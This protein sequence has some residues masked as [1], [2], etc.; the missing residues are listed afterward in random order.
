MQTPSVTVQ[1]SRDHV[2]NITTSSLSL[3]LPS[4]TS[5]PADPHSHVL[6]A[7]RPGWDQPAPSRSQSD[8]RQNM[9]TPAGCR[10]DSVGMPV[11]GG[12]TSNPGNWWLDE[13]E[14]ITNEEFE[15]RMSYQNPR[16]DQRYTAN[17]NNWTGESDRTFATTPTVT[18]GIV[19]G[20]LLEV[21]DLRD[22]MYVSS[23]IRPNTPIPITNFDVSPTTPMSTSSTSETTVPTREIRFDGN[24]H[25][26]G[27]ITV[28]SRDSRV[29]E[30]DLR[31]PVK[32]TST[33][34]SSDSPLQSSGISEVQDMVKTWMGHA[35]RLEEELDMKNRLLELEREQ[36][37]AR[38]AKQEQQHQQVMSEMNR[39]RESMTEF[40]NEWQNTQTNVGIREPTPQSMGPNFGLEGI[41]TQTNRLNMQEIKD[42]SI[43]IPE[44]NVKDVVHWVR[45]I[46]QKIETHRMDD[47]AAKTLIALKGLT[48]HESA[49]MYSIGWQH[50]P[51]QE[52]LKGLLVRY[53]GGDQ[54]TRKRHE[55]QQMKREH[56]QSL[57]SWADQVKLVMA[58][59]SPHADPQDLVAKF[60]DGLQGELHHA[61]LGLE[62]PPA[63][64]EDA[65][66]KA[67]SKEYAL[68]QSRPQN[69]PNTM[70]VNVVTPSGPAVTPQ[71]VEDTRTRELKTQ[72]AELQTLV[73][74]LRTNSRTV[75]CYR[76]GKLGHVRKDCQEVGRPDGHVGKFCE[77]HGNTGH[78][79]AECRSPLNPKGPNY[80]GPANVSDSQTSKET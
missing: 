77:Y 53:Q 57:R 24:G 28:N 56:S 62:N 5:R 80:R 66:Q 67:S 11:Q 8:S 30:L 50:L 16:T 65:F 51:A 35:K 70:S 79:D 27:S 78:N 74:S 48:K 40:A 38:M 54:S 13:T 42:C 2:P 59:V 69:R 64:L 71:N 63:T 49:W 75:K 1:D 31:T 52:I 20:P 39:M 44:Y 17:N 47:A 21:P 26:N 33:K 7:H 43:D 72:L 46:R 36:S 22:P 60:I 58:E 61:M 23:N 73:M 6:Q 14:L 4:G 15:R 34:H 68:I 41:R 29:P 18:R 32:P 55:F 45:F 9:A 19:R 3:P 37:K 10:S 25:F 12:M 76:C